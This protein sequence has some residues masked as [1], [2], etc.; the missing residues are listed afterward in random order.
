MPNQER[1]SLLN[2][3]RPLMTAANAAPV[4][5]MEKQL[6][7]E[8]APAAPMDLPEEP[9]QSY[10]S[11]TVQHHGTK[12]APK[13]IKRREITVPATFRVPLALHERL[14]GIA[15][16]NRL[17]M[18]DILIEALELHLEHFPSPELQSRQSGKPTR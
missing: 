1:G 14:K 12:L 4:D 13:P 7:S 18:T 11:T 17:N 6:L 5:E 3:K 9:M 15:A 8:S 16:H 10:S 2:I